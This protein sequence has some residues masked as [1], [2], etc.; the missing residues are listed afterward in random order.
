MKVVVGDCYAHGNMTEANAVKSRQVNLFVGQ[1]DVPSI[2]FLGSVDD[3]T[4][5]WEDGLWND[6]GHPNSLGHG[7]MFYAIVPTV[8]QALEQGKPYPERDSSAC[9]DLAGR[10]VEFVPAD[11]VHAFAEVLRVKGKASGQIASIEVEPVAVEDTKIESNEPRE[12]VERKFIPSGEMAVVSL[13]VQN[14]ELTYKGLG[15]NTVVSELSNDWNTVA[16]S[17]WYAR[18]ETELYVNGVKAGSVSERFTPSRFTLGGT[19]FSEWFIYRSAL[20]G[21]EVSLL[22]DGGMYQSSLEVY[23]PLGGKDGLENRAQSLSEISAE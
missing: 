14:G 20:N 6:R 22:N 1:L 5:R 3:G 7:E 16:V 4:G 8:W 18:G 23:A 15:T 17:H 21:G 2:N 13:S 19:E 9:L 10:Y 11:P 12:K